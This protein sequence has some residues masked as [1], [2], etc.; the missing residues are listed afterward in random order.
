MQPRLNRL[1]APDGQLL[2]RRRRPRLLR[3]AAL[4]RRAS[5]TWRRGRD[6]SSRPGPT[7][8][9]SRAGQAPLLQAHS[10][11]REARA[12]PADGRRERLRPRGRRPRVLFSQLIEDA[13]EQAVAPRRRLRGRQPPP[14]SRPARARAA[15]ASR[16]SRASAQLRPGGHAA[17]GRAARHAATA[18]AGYGVDGDVDRIVPLVRQAVELG[19][20]VIK[21][22]PTDDLDEYRR[23]VEAAGGVPCSCAAAARVPTTRSCAA[24]RP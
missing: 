17:H 15:S 21:A 24:P 6:S 9:S 12:R 16:T 2:R 1:F 3:R 10:R 19:A 4:P 22:D 8:S 13:V 5:R 23:V 11:P 7:P 18:R 14:S 20:D